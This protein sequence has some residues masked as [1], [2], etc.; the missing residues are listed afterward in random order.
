MAIA[1]VPPVTPTAAQRVAALASWL[2]RGLASLYVCRVPIIAGAA[3]VLLPAI[4]L[5]LAPTLLRN[6]LVLTTWNLF[7]CTAAAYVFAWSIQV[8][9]RIVAINRN[10]RFGLPGPPAA[11]P[12]DWRA[13]L[14]LRLLPVPLLIAVFFSK[15]ENDPAPGWLSYVLAAAGGF[16]L[17][18]ALSFL[19]VFF[20]ALVAP[21]GHVQADHF[22]TLFFAWQNRALRWA[23]RIEPT[24]TGPPDRGIRRWIGQWRQVFGAAFPS[25]YFDHTGRLY[26]GHWIAISSCILSI[27]LFMGLGLAKSPRCPRAVLSP[28]TL[29][30]DDVVPCRYF[31]LPRPLSRPAHR[32]SV[33]VVR[34]ERAAGASPGIVDAPALVSVVGPLLRS[35]QG[36]STAG[37]SSRPGSDLP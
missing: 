27:L 5:W 8:T 35:L 9:Y 18:Y 7:W 14:L 3:L 22:F 17:A 10:E 19:A 11:T 24:R 36:E 25:G 21:E 15:N 29:F 30:P 12:P 23:D 28:A 32:P 20:A 34:A 26:G 6:L 37:T 2:L 31:V 16:A 13:K 33:F 1:A 4:C